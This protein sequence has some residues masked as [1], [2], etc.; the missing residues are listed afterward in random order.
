[1]TQ[2]LLKIAA[3][4]DVVLQNK[5]AVGATTATLSSVTDDDGNA[6]ANGT[7]CFTVDGNNS[8]KEYF[9][10]TITG[11]SVASIVTINRQGTTASGFAREHRKGAKVT[12]T[13]WAV[14][15]RMLSLLDG[16]TDFDASTVLGYDA[17]PTLTPGSNEFATVKYADDLAIAGAPDATTTQKGIVE[18]ATQAEADAGTASGGTGAALLTRTS[19]IRARNINDYVADTGVANAYVIT[20]APAITAYAAGQLFTFK[21]SSANTTASTIN[22]NG[23]GAKNIFKKGDTALA[24]GD[25]LSGQIVMVEYDGTQ[26]QMLSQSGKAKVSQDGL[27]LYA[28][29]SVGTDAY[30]VTLVPAP[31]AYTSGMI[32]NFKAGTVNTGAA[33]LNVNGLGAKT[34]VRNGNVTLSDGDIKSGQVVTVIYDG[35]NFQMQSQTSSPSSRRLHTFTTNVVVASDTN[36]TALLTFTLPGGLLS[37]S[38]IVR[39]LINFSALGNDTGTC[40]LRLKNGATTISTITLSV[41]SFPSVEGELTFEII[42]AGATNSQEGVLRISA[43][44]S[45]SM[46][47]TGGDFAMIRDRVYGTSAVDNTTDQTVAVTVQFS[48]SSASNN[49]TAVNG[50]AELI[51]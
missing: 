39:G 1:M 4:F 3:D 14:M 36:E 43:D 35:T 8:K 12:I 28:V 18:L 42:G 45:N 49:I 11:T 40:T 21:A 25:I 30:A 27:E 26:F 9:I 32:V 15:K 19:N 31:T 10:G 6:L 34:I 16:T 47:I 2:T 38:N 50:Y 5:V 41:T 46:D 48:A 33:T 13:D 7:Y 20:P 51:A 17:A 24:A 23:L 44:T 37:T 29:D 22:V